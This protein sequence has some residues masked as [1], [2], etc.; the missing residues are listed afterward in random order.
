MHV[1]YDMYGILLKLMDQEALPGALA[2]LN[3]IRDS[4]LQLSHSKPNLS[5][6]NVRYCYFW[7]FQICDKLTL[8][9]MVCS[10]RV[11]Q[12]LTSVVPFKLPLYSY[13]CLG[14]IGDFFSFLF[15]A[16]DNISWVKSV[17]IFCRL[18]NCGGYKMRLDCTEWS[19][20]ACMPRI[21]SAL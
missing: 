3:R 21:T 7:C 15:S 16:A 19:M 8:Y 17:G 18:L 4:V 14:L 9:I 10:L 6:Q 5:V 13:C 2:E 12:V 11:L 20:S 1:I